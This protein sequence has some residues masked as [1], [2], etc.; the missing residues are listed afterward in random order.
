MLKKIFATLIATLS[1]FGATMAQA[2]SAQSL[3]LA[4][5]PVVSTRAATSGGEG[6][7]AVAGAGAYALGAIVAGLAIWGLV[8]IIDSSD[9]P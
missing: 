3:S 5:S 9:S 4:N 1:L 2:S 7:D 6:S 8:E